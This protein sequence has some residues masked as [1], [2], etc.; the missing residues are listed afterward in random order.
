VSCLCR[1]R[2]APEA[3]LRAPRL[4]A[5][6]CARWRHHLRLAPFRPDLR[7]GAKRRCVA[8]RKPP[9]VCR[10]A[11]RRQHSPRQ[12]LAAVAA[13]GGR[14]QRRRRR[15]R[16]DRGCPERPDAQGGPAVAP[17]VRRLPP[18]RAAPR[19]A[20]ATPH[21]GLPARGVRGANAWSSFSRGY[22]PVTPGDVVKPNLAA[23]AHHE[24]IKPVPVHGTIPVTF[25]RR[26]PVAH[27]RAAAVCDG[28]LT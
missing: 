23:I 1:R 7:V 22:E 27:D 19:R 15:H 5:P 16:H 12:A 4:S 8:E 6:F 20:R 17:L 2:Q 9:V 24:V 26:L 21:R 13:R 3:P 18:R 10:Q 28:K 25:L 11:E 14:C